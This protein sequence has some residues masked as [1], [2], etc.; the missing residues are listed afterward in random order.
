MNAFFVSV[1]NAKTSPQEFQTLEVRERLG[2]GR[3]PVSLGGSG[4]R[5]STQNQENKSMGPDG[6]H[7]HM[8]RKLA[9]MTAEPI[10]IIFLS[11][12]L[13]NGRCA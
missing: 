9:E 13:V 5:V 8:L 4:Q 6:M 10:S 1:F 7:P 12:A 2:K 3:L 11:K